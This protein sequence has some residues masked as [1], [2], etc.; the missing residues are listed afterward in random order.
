MTLGSRLKELREEK[1]MT[2]KDIAE[3]LGISDVGLGNYER[4]VRNPDP[5]TLKRL[6]E[7]FNCSVDYLLGNT[8]KRKWDTETIA[9]SSVS[10]DG[11]D[12]EEIAQ[13]RGMIELLKKKHGK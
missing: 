6:S 12:E 13:I 2:Q 5:D 3:L 1:G 4:G 9:F 11:L 8:N 10:V 7:I